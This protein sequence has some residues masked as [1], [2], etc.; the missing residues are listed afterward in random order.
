MMVGLG[1][2][3]LTL[4]SE[5]IQWIVEKDMTTCRRSIHIIEQ[6][7][8]KPTKA[9]LVPGRI[10]F[11][12]LSQQI[13]PQG[14]MKLCNQCALDKSEAPWLDSLLRDAFKLISLCK[15]MGLKPFQEWLP[16]LPAVAK[17]FLVITFILEQR[18]V[19]QG[20]LDLIADTKASSQSVANWQ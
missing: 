14:Q 11:G 8:G 12:V 5:E 3:V 2:P 16:Y 18:T 7:I 10:F 9:W 13:A 17:N 4:R 6:W 15:N 19:L 1:R 20:N